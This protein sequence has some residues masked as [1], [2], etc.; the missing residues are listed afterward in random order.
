MK[1]LLKLEDA[2]KF[3]LAYFATIHLGYSWWFFLVW[4]LAPDLSM[5]GYLINQKVGA[6]LYN[7]F[8][9]QGVAIIVFIIG[10]LSLN[11]E[12]Q[13]AGVI[14]FGHSAMDRLFGYGLKYTDHFQNTHLGKIGKSKH[15]KKGEIGIKN[16]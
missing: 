5:V 16:N 6:Y 2:A 3:F 8:H 4:L 15:H 12:I 13:V 9:H 11:M 14:L 7:F 10:T 1:T